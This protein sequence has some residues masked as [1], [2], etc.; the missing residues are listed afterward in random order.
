MLRLFKKDRKSKK[1][2]EEVIDF[3]LNSGGIEYAERKMREISSEA[4]AELQRLP[5]NDARESLIELV[6]YTIDREK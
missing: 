5:Q 2:V 3:V 4:I 1:D 6:Q